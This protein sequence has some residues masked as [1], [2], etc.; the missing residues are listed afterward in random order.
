[1]LSFPKLLTPST[2]VYWWC[3]GIMCFWMLHWQQNR[4]HIRLFSRCRYALHFSY[5]PE[6]ATS[7]P[8]IQ[9]PCIIQLFMNPNGVDDVRFHLAYQSSKAMFFLFF[10]LL[11]EAIWQASSLGRFC[12]TND[13]ISR[14]SQN[15]FYIDACKWLLLV[16]ANKKA[17]AR[18]PHACFEFSL[19][20]HFGHDNLLI[21]KFLWQ[22]HLSTFGAPL[23]HSSEISSLKNALKNMLFLHLISLNAK[24]P[25][26]V[27]T[28]ICM[29][30]LQVWVVELLKQHIPWLPAQLVLGT[31]GSPN[32]WLWSLT[33][34][35]YNLQDGHKECTHL[36]QVHP[37]T[38]HIGLRHLEMMRLLLL[39]PP[40][41][42]MVQLHLNLLELVMYQQEGNELRP[43]CHYSLEP[44]N[45]LEVGVQMVVMVMM[46]MLFLA[47]VI[48]HQK[49]SLQLQENPQ[50]SLWILSQ[51]VWT[52]FQGNPEPC[53][54]QLLHWKRT[55]H[56]NQTAAFHQLPI[57][58][59]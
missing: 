1:M 50:V 14:N 2:L 43:H 28:Y 4:D 29:Y 6:E 21:N 23:L 44:H 58:Q 55:S 35:S 45:Q 49:Q 7:A 10:N 53:L 34:N 8:S 3:G 46:W 18:H 48:A 56:Y 51:A 17:N 9:K 16:F 42:L 41:H 15:N 32:S 22:I 36:E 24:L 47:Q 57:H 11:L 38:L 19:G 27:C 26:Y 12:V 40:S 33:N 31:Q 39:L 20:L 52:V 54:V 59:T 5:V 13:I 37:S 25:T 30:T